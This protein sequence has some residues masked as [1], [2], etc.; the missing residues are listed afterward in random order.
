M[1]FRAPE[2][3]PA[4]YDMNARFPL[5]SKILLWFFLNLLIVGGAIYALFIFQFRAGPEMLLGAEDSTQ[6][7]STGSTAPLFSISAL[8]CWCWVR[9]DH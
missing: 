5:Y 1:E 6:P 9:A 2:A 4:F 8:A 3:A 7:S